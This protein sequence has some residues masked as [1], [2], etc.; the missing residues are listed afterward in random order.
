M[1]ANGNGGIYAPL[2]QILSDSESED[3]HKL[4]NAVHM[5]GTDS[6]NNLDYNSG[7]QT[8][9]NY[10]L[11]DMDEF[12]TNVNTVES[13]M[14]NVSFLQSDM[15]NKMST[16]RRCAFFASILMCVFT[17]V[18]FLWG[19][20]CSDVGGCPNAGFQDKTTSWEL[21]YDEIELSGAVQVVDGAIANTKNLIFIYRGNHMRVQEKNSD[22]NVNGVLLIVGNSGK[23]G[24]YTREGR[25]PTEINCHLID[26]NKDKQKDCIVSGSEGLLAALNP[27]YGTYYWYFHKH[28]KMF[29][30]IAAIDFP[31]VMKDM[32]QDKTNDLLTVATVYPN[33]N[34][35]SLLVISGATG[36]II[37]EPITIEDCL[38]VK[39]LTESD[40]ITYICKNGTS[41]AVRLISYDMLTRKKSKANQTLNK[42]PPV[43]AITKRINLSL[44]KNIGNT[45][46]VFPNGPGKLI[47]ENS[48]ECP[49]NCRV[50]LKLV[51][52]R[53]GTTNWNSAHLAKGAL[54][55]D[56]IKYNVQNTS[57]KDTGYDLFYSRPTINVASI[58]SFIKYANFTAHDIS[59]RIVLVSF[60]KLQ[61]HN[62]NVSQTD[63]VQ[64]CVRGPIDTHAPLP[65]CQ[66]DLEYQEKS[67]MI[68][69]LDGDQSHELISYY[70]TFVA[71]ESYT[72]K[73]SNPYD[74][75]R[76]TSMVRVIRLETE[77]PKLFVTEI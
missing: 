26:V 64:I 62:V 3:D 48:G 42:S 14:D 16:P 15:S 73:N 24:W 74:N 40:T 45:R 1:S 8:S 18:I 38:S 70:S 77:L 49:N 56:D 11:S 43:S 27:L 68:A 52:E 9:K 20:P 63:I 36:N 46:E 22:D 17:V 29:N 41:E 61:T 34:H 28:E 30:N 10:S 69:D 35:N 57:P 4:E 55:I 25:I 5:K 6:C 33:P 37:R 31:I 12:N 51:L 65:I 67:L 2:K 72:P 44:K 7:L 59:E 47:V 23:V 66:P 60:D 32:D 53:N 19:I 54:K 71:P 75:W 76:L 50:T 39:L 58:S 13:T 21:P